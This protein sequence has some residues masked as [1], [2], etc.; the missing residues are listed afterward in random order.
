MNTT[1]SPL[2][3]GQ[4]SAETVGTRN[5]FGTKLDFQRLGKL[6]LA[7]AE[8]LLRSW[9]PDGRRQGNEWVARNPTRYDKN[10]GSFKINMLTGQWADFAAGA[11]G[12]DLISLKAYLEQISQRDAA[13]HLLQE[14]GCP[15]QANANS[16][17]V[18]D[19][20]RKSTDLISREY[21]R[22]A[23]PA[24]GSIVERY[25]V[26]RALPAGLA[27]EFELSYSRPASRG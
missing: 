6:A 23:R 26:T 11:S 10:P 20:S 2:Y 3:R 21:W 17:R 25:L 9:L 13:N 12:G 15:G 8:C 4:G 22:D 1:S 14:I 7:N 19:N 24:N 5:R 18:R 27:G 16:H